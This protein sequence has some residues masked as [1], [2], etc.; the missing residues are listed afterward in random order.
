[1]TPPRRGIARFPPRDRPP[2]P[3]GLATTEQRVVFPGDS[4]TGVKDPVVRLDGTRWHA[5][6]HL[7][8][9]P[10]AEDLMEMAHAS[11]D[12]GITWSPPERSLR[13]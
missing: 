6:C 4:E 7:L 5:C 11:S 2:S 9:V 12:D 1:M 10:G 13:G 8:D 3:E